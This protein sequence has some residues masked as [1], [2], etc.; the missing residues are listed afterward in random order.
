MFVVSQSLLL[1]FPSIE[2]FIP[3][4]SPLILLSTTFLIAIHYLI[5]IIETAKEADGFVKHTTFTKAFNQLFSHESS[6]SDLSIV[7]YTSS[8]W[9]EHIRLCDVTIE[10]LRILLFYDDDFLSKNVDED[11]TSSRF[12]IDAMI[13]SWKRLVADKKIMSYEIRRIRM[14][15]PIYFGIINREKGM[16]GYLWPRPGISGLEPRQAVFFY[17]RSEYS[18]AMLNH[19]KEWFEAMWN[20]AEKLP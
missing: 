19:S 20:I 4:Q 18:T 7:A 1:I 6:I 2:N 8:T 15:A 3:K 11:I 5:K 13:A 17:S 9:F 14:I 10:N 12:N 16:F